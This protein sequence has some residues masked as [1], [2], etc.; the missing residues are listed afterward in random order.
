MSPRGLIVAT[1]IVGAVLMVSAAAGAS[2]KTS[3]RIYEAFKPTGSPAISV[4][5]TIRGHCFAGSIADDRNDAWRC[6]SGN[7]LYDP[8]FSSSKAGGIVLCPVA[9]WKQSG[10]EI[11][12]TKSL[13]GGNTKKPSTHGLPWAIETT[14]G[15]KC[16]FVTSMQPGIG[17]H[18]GSYA[19][20]KGS[21][22]LWDKPNRKT[23]P[24]TMYVAPATAKSLSKKAKIKIAWF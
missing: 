22:Y 19:C 16:A 6:L 21:E 1:M 15:L 9:A 8:C 7:L 20:A 18:F 4:T 3:A 14:T 23:E 2:Q 13:S 10:I 11:K 24:W 12:L 17:H 5:K